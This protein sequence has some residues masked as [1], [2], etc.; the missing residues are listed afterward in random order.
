MA[1]PTKSEP[2]RTRRHVYFAPEETGWVDDLGDGTAEVNN[3]PYSGPYNLGDIVEIAQRGSAWV[4]GAIKSVAYPGRTAVNYTPKTTEKF[5]EVATALRVAG[6]GCEGW[7]A[8]LAGVACREADRSDIV[9]ALR[10]VE[11]WTLAAAD[12]T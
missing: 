12:D 3:I 6:L 7:V 11:G 5:K 1:A 8:G 2:T 10:G 9:E 4:L